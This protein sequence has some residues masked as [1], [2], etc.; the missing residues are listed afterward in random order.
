MMTRLRS[1]TENPPV[2]RLVY[3]PYLELLPLGSINLDTIARGINSTYGEYTS[4]GSVQVSGRALAVQFTFER[5]KKGTELG[6]FFVFGSFRAIWIR[7]VSIA[8]LGGPCGHSFGFRQRAG[9]RQTFLRCLDRHCRLQW[10]GR[11]LRIA[12]TSFGYTSLQ[13][14]YSARG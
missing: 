4:P 13:Q 3:S 11:S 7:S 5:I 14:R 12:D 1:P 8:R 6:A 2:A 9:S 10:L